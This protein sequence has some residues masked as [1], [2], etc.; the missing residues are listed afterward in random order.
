MGHE[1]VKPVLKFL[2]AHKVNLLPKTLACALS[3]LSFFFFTAILSLRAA[4]LWS[5]PNLA[6]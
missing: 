1:A 3:V 5:F 6:H 2:H 4:A